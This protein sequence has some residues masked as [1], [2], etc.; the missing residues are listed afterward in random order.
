MIEFIET[1]VAGR[2]REQ[3]MVDR[4]TEFA[5]QRAMEIISEATRH[6][7]DDLRQ[8]APEIPWQSIRAIGNIL[9]H[10]YHRI[11]DEIIWDVIVA[12]LPRLKIAIQR[13]RVVT[14]SA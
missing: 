9:R 14:N 5:F 6:I 3:V 12:D 7:P 4:L 2:P 10:E 1:T 13:L 11:A 8:R